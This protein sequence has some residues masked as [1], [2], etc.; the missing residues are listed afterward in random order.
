[1]NPFKEQMKQ[2]IDFHQS[3]ETNQEG[4]TMNNEIHLESM[5]EELANT[6]RENHELKSHC[7]D[8]RKTL[9]E[10]VNLECCRMDEES[11]MASC[12]INRTSKQSLS[13]NNAQVIEKLIYNGC[14]ILA[15]TEIITELQEYADNL[16][17]A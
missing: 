16:R 15:Q 12:A 17:K 11:D 10:I 5:K 9:N 14:S 1:M 2:D 6:E 8:L 4:K 13:E 7:N 3:I